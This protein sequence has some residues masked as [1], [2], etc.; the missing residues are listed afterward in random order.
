MRRLNKQ[1]GEIKMGH[2]R[3]DTERMGSTALLLAMALLSPLFTGCGKLD[4]LQPLDQVIETSVVPNKV[5]VNFCTD[6]AYDQ[7]QY[8]KT[9]IILDHSGSNQKNYLM[10][11]DGSGAPKL[12]NGAPVVSAQY[13]TDPMG[14]TRYGSVAT[15]GTL[16]NYLSALPANDPADPTKFFALVDFST[17]ATTY[18]ANSSGFTSDIN[19]FYNYV[20]QDSKAGGTTPA[21]GGSTD[22]L[23]ALSA[24]YRIMNKDVQDATRCAALPLGSASPGT[25]CPN[26]GKQ[27]ASSYVVVFM[28]DGSPITD[29]SGIGVDQNGNVVVTGQITITKEAATDILGQVGAMTA[30][31][32]NAKYVTS[33]N[34]FTIYYYYPG[35]VDAS[36][37]ALLGN[38]AKVG[39]GIAYNALSGSNIDYSK[40]QPP[41]KRIKYTLADVFV[42]NASAAWW[43]DNQ[44]HADTDMDGLPDDVELL[45]GSDP[46]KADTD[47]NGV[48]DLVEYQLTNGG[49]RTSTINYA[50]GACS[51][52][53]K[54]NVGGATV[55]KSSDPN[56]LNDCEKLLLNDV[57]GIDNPDSNSDLI[58]DFM[59]FKS[60][61]PFQLGTTPAINVRDQDGFTIYQKIKWSL[62]VGVSSTQLMN[63]TP[64]TY[65]LNLVST[66]DIQD[67]YRLNVTN[68]PT[69]GTNDTV[70]V[71]IIEKSELLRENALYR[72][73]KKSFNGS[74]SLQFMDWTDAAEKA[75]N[76]WSVWP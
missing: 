76:T 57:G 74:K 47:G 18:P 23:A 31:T 29:L 67:C 70:R 9:I 7:K 41:A 30:L 21:D 75:A 49:M 60:G 12:V 6:P 22:Y 33:V 17:Q 61:L 44:L 71:D 55:F 28:S 45:W 14:L 2:G 63:F 10:A 65:D 53:R 56:G 34:L 8:L 73:A 37:Q 32:S 15:P 50:S 72:V 48:S 5:T 59:E 11:A 39:N 19:G 20:L 3:N 35:N 62:P 58:P 69:M 42:T 4:V 36:G 40:F 43:S 26:P 46:T 64:A 66:N 51:G 13:A 54:S 27:V 68:L 24:A 16:L 38:M 52:I 1:V 25:W